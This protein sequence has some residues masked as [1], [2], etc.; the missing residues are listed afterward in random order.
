MAEASG[1]SPRVAPAQGAAPG[2]L[3]VV[4]DNRVNRLLLV[5]GL[6]QQGHSVAFAENGRQALDRLRAEPFDLVLLDIEMPEMDGFE[7]LQQLVHDPELK[8]LPV[9]MV[10]AMEELDAVVKCIELGAEDY[11]TK[12][13]NPV[14]LRA[15]VNASLEKKRLRDQQ[16]R[17]FRTF[18]ASQVA[19]ELLQKGLSL[20]G[21][22]VY[23]SVMFSDIRG[24]TSLSEGRDPE[25]IIELLN[26]YYALMF[27]AVESHGGIVSLIQGDGL[28]AIFGAPA[29]RPDHAEQAVRAALEMLSM[30]D[31]FNQQQAALSGPQLRI[32]VGIASGLMVAGYAGT[33][34]RATYTCIGD[35]V[36]LAARLEA[37]T[38]E[39]AHRIL[40]DEDT[41][42]RLPESIHLDPLG[43]T[44]FK[45]RSERVA[46]YAIRNIA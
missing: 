15:R 18:A 13:A 7:V 40:V 45:G 11:L 27:E 10:S 1:T 42:G 26:D 29:H 39:T 5:R 28:M 19:E 25:E 34:E 43:E 23:A 32:G 24:F 16:R 9:I 17:L 2:R 46:V 41:R 22:H 31:E 30:L 12:P 14:L 35:P 21:R 44:L 38:K 20:G 4:D 37:H 36:N 6:E 8:N 3:L 33:R